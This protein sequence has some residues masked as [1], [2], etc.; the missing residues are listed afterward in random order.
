MPINKNPLPN[1]VI[2]GLK[3]ILGV[4]E[5]ETLNQ[6]VF[7]KQGSPPGSKAGFSELSNVFDEMSKRFGECPSQGLAHQA[8][9]ASFKYCQMDYSDQLQ[10]SSL[11]MRTKPLQTRLREGL[12]SI[13]ACL[14]AEF[15]VDITFEENQGGWSWLVK[16]CPECMDRQSQ[17]S[18]CY[19]TA[20]LIQEYLSWSGGSKFYPVEEIACC[21]KGDPHCEYRI[22][23]QPVD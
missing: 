23:S 17:G 9:G 5:W 20:G 10:L 14:K 12:K 15:G 8:G 6:R 16:G 4:S 13:A 3:E 11:E 22:A 7:Q 18:I 1:F 2:K 21:A 19:F